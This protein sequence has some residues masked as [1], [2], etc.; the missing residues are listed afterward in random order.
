MRHQNTVFHTLQKFIPWNDFEMLVEKH[1]ADHR[2]RSFGTKSQFLA[3]LFGQLSGAA[4]LREIVDSLQSQSSR[5]YHLGMTAPARSTFCDAN[6]LRPS[7][8]FADLFARMAQRACRATR[9]QM[10]GADTTLLLDSTQLQLTSLSGG[11]LSAKADGSRA[12]KLHVVHDLSRQ[13]PVKAT[14]SD[15]RVND[16]TP[17]QDLPVEPGATYVFDLGYY[18][19]AWWAAFDAAGCRFVTRLKSHTQLT[20]T[21]ETGVEPGG[22]VL[23]DRIGLLA[24][25]TAKSRT[26]AFIDPVREI[27]VTISTGKT[28]RIVTNDLDAPAEEIADLYKQRWQ[29][30]LFFKWIKQNLK[31][32]T[33]VGTSEN[34]IRIQIFV[35]L[36]AYILLRMAHDAQKTVARPLSFRR[37][38]RFNLMEKRD[39]TDLNKPRPPLQ[40][41]P[42]QG[43]FDLQVI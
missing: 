36:I 27:A 21:A 20:V 42:R 18:D 23:S 1:G 14:I 32:K 28:I 10:G 29:I 35:A 22:A 37:L 4:S 31:I 24:Q 26:P 40:V 41:D 25:R 6:R 12:L 13:T 17:A 8:L 11:W 19:F 30:E 39:V 34:A 2:V 9:Q 38:V 33:F 43:S 15:Q 7:A 3:L 16:I 5:L